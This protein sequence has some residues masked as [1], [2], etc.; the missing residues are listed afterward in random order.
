M[1]TSKAG[2]PVHV[3]ARLGTACVLLAEAA[4]SA[5]FPAG[6]P[7]DEAAGKPVDEASDLHL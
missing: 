6:K 7:V 1:A 5:G 2:N 3:S 4:S